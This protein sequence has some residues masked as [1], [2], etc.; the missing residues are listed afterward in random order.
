[1]LIFLRGIYISVSSRMFQNYDLLTLIPG[2]KS[3]LEGSGVP[4][5]ILL[6]GK[7]ASFL[8]GPCNSKIFAV[9]KY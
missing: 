9:F 4:S 2:S 8:T 1:M 7:K 3:I 5:L 6:R